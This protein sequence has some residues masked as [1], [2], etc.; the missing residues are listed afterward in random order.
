MTTLALRNT[1]AALGGQLGP[2][3]IAQVHRLYLA[4]QAR[5]ADELAPA[6]LDLA[7][8]PHPRHRL[9]LYGGGE[10]GALAPILVWVHGGGFMR[11]DKRSPDHPYEAHAGRFAARHGFLGVTMNYRLAP[12]HGW[13]AG[14]EDVGL[15]IDWLRDKAQA[16]GG[17][18]DRILLVGTSAGATHVAAHLQLRPESPGIRGAVLLSG[19]YGLTPSDGERDAAYYGDDPQAY[20]AHV[21][22]EA[23][24]QTPTPL[25]LCCAEFDPP[26]FQRE[27][28]AVMQRRLDHH[29]Q[30]PRAWIATSHNHYS[31]AYHLGTADHRLAGEILDFAAACGI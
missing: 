27:F 22:A 11:G 26:R 17:D 2:D 5:H 20:A 16:H 13:P 1:L 24:I 23:I 10:A 4:E 28:I 3:T 7:Y 18:P 25:L 29:G 19:L 6:A 9:D 12:Q 14:G 30:A 8:G 21:P 15:V 31:I